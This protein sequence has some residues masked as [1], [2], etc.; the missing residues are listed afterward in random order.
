MFKLTD[1]LKKHVREAYNLPADA[2]DELYTKTI[3]DKIKDGSLTFDKLAE[4]TAD[5]KPD[6]KSVVGTMVKEA[7]SPLEKALATIAEGQARLTQMMADTLQKSLIKPSEVPAPLQDA[8]KNGVVPD[9]KAVQAGTQ[10][11]PN[12][13]EV[14]KA[15]AE[16]QTRVKGVQ[17]RYSHTTKAAVYPNFSAKNT[18][19]PLAGRPATFAGRPI[20]EPSELAKAVSGA[21]FKWAIQGSLLPNEKQYVPLTEHD[22]ELVQYALNECEWTGY[23]KGYADDGL[24]NVSYLQNRDGCTLVNRQK[25]TEMQRKDILDDVTSGGISAV[26]LYFDDA[27]VL[28]PVLYGEVFPLVEVINMARGR[29]ID[30]SSMSNPTWTWGTAEGTSITPFSTTSFIA[31]MD[32]TIYPIVGAVNLGLDFESDSPIDVGGN[33]IRKFGEKLMEQLD[34]VVCTGASGSSQPTGI[35]NASG[36]TTITPA[37]GAGGAPTISDYEGLYFGVAKAF[38]RDLGGLARSV[39]IGNETSYRRCRGIPV[40]TSDARRVFGM[41]HGDYM[42]MD[43]PYKIVNALTNQQ[44]AFCNLAGY[45]MYRRLGM[46]VRVETGGSTLALKNERLIVVRGRFGGTLTLSGYASVMTAAQA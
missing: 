40:G 15:A 4:L 7:V 39:F 14:M 37:N 1:P 3:Q 32:S 10:T 19:H 46:T 5:P 30:G 42:V 13:T 34:T 43:R 33:I 12:P 29:L 26:P 31:A 38:R 6:A 8:A 36:T 27:M 21:Y 22:K 2:A 16:A 25:L 35:F 17:E 41:T 20:E 18:P 28:T 44:I 45:R 9:T 23:V 11:A 24:A